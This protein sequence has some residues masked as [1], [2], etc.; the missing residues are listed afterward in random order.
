[1]AKPLIPKTHCIRVF[2][3]KDERPPEEVLRQW[4]NHTLGESAMETGAGSLTR[5]MSIVRKGLRAGHYTH[6][7]LS[8]PVAMQGLTKGQP[9]P[10]R[11][12][13]D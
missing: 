1:M 5:A 9:A 12:L 4:K 6:F 13:K 3:W 10:M 11:L 8:Y 2:M 7:V